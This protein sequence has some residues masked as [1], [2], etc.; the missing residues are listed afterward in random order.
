M[1][2]LGVCVVALVILGTAAPSLLA[3]QRQRG[4]RG[5]GFGGAG[6]DVVSL[7]NQRSVQEELKL[8]EDQVKKISELTTTQNLVIVT[9]P[10]CAPGTRI[11]WRGFAPLWFYERLAAEQE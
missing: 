1:K 10:S 4:Q 5:A 3:Q 6:R 2:K 11:T 9:H 8:S 7:L